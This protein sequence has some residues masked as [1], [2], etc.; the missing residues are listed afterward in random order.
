MMNSEIMLFAVRPDLQEEGIGKILVKECLDKLKDRGCRR[1]TL[2]TSRICNY[3]FYDHLGFELGNRIDV[4]GV[5][6]EM[7]L[8]TMEL[9]T[10]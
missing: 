4:G 10:G 5:S 8:Y 9:R 1:V 3:D 6:S 7:L 2:M